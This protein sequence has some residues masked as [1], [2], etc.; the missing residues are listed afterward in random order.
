MNNNKQVTRAMQAA[1]ETKL[2]YY[3]PVECIEPVTMFG[4]VMSDNRYMQL[5]QETSV[6]DNQRSFDNVFTMLVTP[7]QFKS[8]MQ[9][10]NQDFVQ[11]FA[12]WPAERVDDFNTVIG[13]RFRS[14]AA[15]LNAFENWQLAVDK[16]IVKAPIAQSLLDSFP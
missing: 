14:K 8:A 16:K 3:I 15:L 1:L 5:T 6:G 10:I 13:Y 7:E 4:Q 11:Y 12:A 2:S 9:S